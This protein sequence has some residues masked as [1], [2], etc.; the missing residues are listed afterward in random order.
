MP[1]LLIRRRTS[2]QVEWTL[3][4]RRSS[5]SGCDTST[6][7]PRASPPAARTSAATASIRSGAMSA[8]AT[9]MPSAPARRARPAPIPEAA[10]V[11]TAT[12]PAK[13][14]RSW[15]MMAPAS[16]LGLVEH[17]L[18]MPREEVVELD[19]EVFPQRAAA[20]QVGFDEGLTAIFP[21]ALA[22]RGTENRGCV[23]A[24]VDLRITAPGAV[25][26]NL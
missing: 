13:T 6:T 23:H 17:V 12:P 24:R 14:S 1:A 26:D 15:D 4:A 2:P 10:P 11:M 20:E 22:G 8:S 9:F 19:H 5:C 16:N 18:R 7:T 21:V 3:S 25:G